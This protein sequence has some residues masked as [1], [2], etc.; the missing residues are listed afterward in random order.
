MQFLSRSNWEGHSYQTPGCVP[1]GSLPLTH[2]QGGRDAS[3]LLFRASSVRPEERR[4][5][6]GGG[7]RLKLE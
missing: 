3:L 4:E 6:E 2:L 7:L 1:G 5:G